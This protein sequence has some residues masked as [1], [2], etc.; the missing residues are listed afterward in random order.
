VKAADFA[1]ENHRLPRHAWWRI[2]STELEIKDAS[3]IFGQVWNR[4][5]QGARPGEHGLPILCQN[6]AEENARDF[7]NVRPVAKGL[8]G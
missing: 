6:S 5:G 4:R 1:I 3:L 8:Y 2:A 7:R